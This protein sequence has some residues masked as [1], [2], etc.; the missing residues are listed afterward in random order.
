MFAFYFFFYSFHLM[1]KVNLKQKR[2]VEANFISKYA[3]SNA[4][5]TAGELICLPKKKKKKR[6]AKVKGN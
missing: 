5:C 1:A 6:T 4:R 2:T 3:S